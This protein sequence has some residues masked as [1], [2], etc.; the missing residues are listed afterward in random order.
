MSVEHNTGLVPIQVLGVTD[1]PNT[2][3]RIVILQDAID[4]DVLPI[5]MGQ[6]EGDAI[7]YALE[8]IVPPRPTS[9]DLLM[10]LSTHLDVT[11]TQ[12]VVTDVQN[13]TYYAAIHLR[14][15]ERERT[16]DARPSDA[17]ALALRAKCPMYVTR[18]VLTKGGGDNV[19]AWLAK[20]DLKALGRSEASVD[21]P[22]TNLTE[23]T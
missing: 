7:R 14:S 17:I 19:A 8:H 6:V 10:S 2:E 18:D 22:N 13:N 20:L 3:T 15:N 21:S 16:V 4:A 23:N 5:W 12:V 9:H 11:I 1:D